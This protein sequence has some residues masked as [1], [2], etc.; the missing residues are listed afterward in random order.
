M[1][2]STNVADTVHVPHYAIRKLA[3]SPALGRITRD[4]DPDCREPSPQGSVFG[5]LGLPRGDLG[6]HPNPAIEG[7]LKT[8]HR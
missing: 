7:H 4:S 8:G 5:V 3:C 1:V 2:G 6:G